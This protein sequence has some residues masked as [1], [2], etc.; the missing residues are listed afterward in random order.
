MQR[1]V[2]KLTRQ[3]KR[4]FRRTM[5]KKIKDARL[6]TRYLIILHTA[7]GYSRRKI[8]RMLL[9]SASTVDRVRKRFAEEAEL[10]LID[11][12]GDNGPAKVDEDYI[13][14][15]IKAVERTPLEYGYRRPTWTQELVSA[16]HAVPCVG[17][18]GDWVSDEE[19]RNPRSA[20]RGHSEHTNAVYG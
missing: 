17:C 11:R 12:R 4:N 16:Y 13:L 9:C 5:S 3:V 6:K 15:L 19:C 1:I 14:A 18:F 10:G 20:V 8:A 7:E 2:I